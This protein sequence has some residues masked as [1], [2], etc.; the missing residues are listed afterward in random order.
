MGRNLCGTPG[1]VSLFPVIWSATP[2]SCPARL[3][4]GTRRLSPLST[5]LLLSVRKDSHD[6]WPAVKV[7]NW[8]SN[9]LLF[10]Y[11]TEWIPCIGK[12]M[13]KC[14]ILLVCVCVR[15][16]DRGSR[17]KLR[18][19]E[20]RCRERERESLRTIG[21]R[22]TPVS[23]LPFPQDT[24]SMLSPW[25]LRKPGCLQGSGWYSAARPPPSSMW[26]SNSIGRTLVRPWSVLVLCDGSWACIL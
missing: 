14:R 5:L 7:K 13:S 22:L 11:W 25:P 15:G 20:S 1:G 6:K 12:A 19:R 21:R 2:G 4:L 17:W 10:F 18:V 9:L 16:R 8:R 3:V 24:R 23:A 26:A